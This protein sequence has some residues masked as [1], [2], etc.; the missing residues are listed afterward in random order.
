MRISRAAP[1]VLLLPSLALGQ[2]SPPKRAHHALVYD[3][4]NARV[5]LTGGS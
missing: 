1:I 2:G 4:A 3:E 5:L